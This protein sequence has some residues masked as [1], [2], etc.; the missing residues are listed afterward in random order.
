VEAMRELPEC[1]LR[2]A[3]GSDARIAEIGALA[4]SLGVADG[5]RLLG[6]IEPRRRFEVIAAADICLL[7]LRPVAI[8]ARYTSPLK[9]FEYMAMGKP[10]VASDLA[11]LREVLADGENALLVPP[12]DPVALAGAVRKLASD[13]ALALKLGTAAY[14]AAREKYGWKARAKR[15]AGFIRSA[16]PSTVLST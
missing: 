4:G 8:G 11:S 9:L 10:I 2:I 3:G 15:L 13:R 16:L 7:P 12:E 1:E 6:R 5:V 14:A